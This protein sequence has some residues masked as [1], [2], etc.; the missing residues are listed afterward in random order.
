MENLIYNHA[1][2]F[3]LTIHEFT[4]TWIESAAKVNGDLYYDENEEFWKWRSVEDKKWWNTLNNN[5]WKVTDMLEEFE[6][7]FGKEAAEEAMARVQQNCACDIEDMPF[8][9]MAALE[10][11]AKE[12]AARNQ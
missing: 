1:T 7:Q 12:R 3:T 8:A 4:E 9:M 5:F 10:E 2:D 6:S 11:Y